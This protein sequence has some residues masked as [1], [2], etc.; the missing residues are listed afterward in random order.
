MDGKVKQRKDNFFILK[1]EKKRYFLKTKIRC[2]DRV[3]DTRTGRM[4]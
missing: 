3:Q 2:Y 1:K 4:H